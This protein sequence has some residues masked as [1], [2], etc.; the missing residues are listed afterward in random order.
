MKV[1]M[2]NLLVAC[3]NCKEPIEAAEAE[4]NTWGYIRHKECGQDIAV[5]LALMKWQR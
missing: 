5:M 1:T 3:V 2:W 4:A